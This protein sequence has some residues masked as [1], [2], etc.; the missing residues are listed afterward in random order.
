MGEWTL[1]AYADLI[2]K[3]IKAGYKPMPVA[4]YLRAPSSNALILRHD[5]DRFP[6]NAVAMGAAEA[7]L[8]IRSTYYVRHRRQGFPADAIATLN[9]QG[10]EIGYHYEVLSRARGDPN[11]AVSLFKSELDKLRAKVPVV[12]TTA[13]GSPMSKWDNRLFWEHA[14]PSE[15]DLVGD[16]YR[17]IDFLNVAYFTDTGRTWADTGVNLRDRVDGPGALT[18]E[19]VAL[20]DLIGFIQSHRAMSVC[21][22][23]HPERWNTYWASR[24]RS[25]SW[26]YSTNMAKTLLKL[27]VA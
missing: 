17:D 16:G 14:K 18:N 8:G 5:V 15:F 10:H 23:T 1:S 24:I 6:N 12:T 27:V 4:D 3:A 19:V 7:D 25:M 9:Q 22:Q 13:H 26:D 11:L 2:R 20:Q 21:L